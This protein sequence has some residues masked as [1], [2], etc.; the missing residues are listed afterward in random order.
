[1]SER[2]AHLTRDDRHSWT[3]AISPTDSR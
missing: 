2:P 3:L 1:V